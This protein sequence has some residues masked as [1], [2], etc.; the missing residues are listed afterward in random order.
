[1]HYNEKSKNNSLNE[2]L[3]ENS[4]QKKRRNRCQQYFGRLNE[5]ILRPM[6]IYKYEKNEERRAY[7]FFEIF[8]NDGKKIKQDFK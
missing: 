5:F 4:E 3:I 6:F 1:M 8:M 2:Q 7:E